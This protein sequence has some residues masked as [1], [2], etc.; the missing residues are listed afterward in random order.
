MPQPAHLA[1]YSRRINAQLWDKI[2]VATNTK[3]IS[4][5]YIS[6]YSSLRSR[7]GQPSEINI[8]YLKRALGI[9]ISINSA[10]RRQREKLRKAGER[11]EDHGWCAA[12]KKFCWSLY[13]SPCA[14]DF[15]PA[16]HMHAERDLNWYH[17]V[18]SL[19]TRLVC[20]SADC[21][22]GVSTL[23]WRAKIISIKNFSVGYNRI[24]FKSITYL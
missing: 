11:E 10:A 22:S 17:S 20:N 16:A 14:T 7:S 18:C 19:R 9:F 15:C 21:D 12:Q 23:R 6:L 2:Y 13:L 1:S 5:I 24:F 8:I 3:P 4:H